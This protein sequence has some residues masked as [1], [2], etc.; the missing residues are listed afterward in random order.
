MNNERRL[1]EERG[2]LYPKAPFDFQKSLSFLCSFNAMKNEQSI[3]SGTMIKAFSVQGVPVVIELS[4]EGSVNC[5]IVSYVLYS[6]DELTESQ[7]QEV[8]DR[9]D[10]FLSLS[11]DL[12]AFYDIGSKDSYFEPVLRNCYGYHQV[13]FMTPFE[14]AC[15]AILVQRNPM[16]AACQLKRKLYEGY[17]RTLTVKGTEHF[18]FPEPADLLGASTEALVETFGSKRA[19]YLQAV[20]RA[21]AQTEAIF[22]KAG[23]YASVREWLLS[24]K[25]IGQWSVDFIL[26]R[27]LGRM[28]QI[29]WQE[30]AA[31]EAASAVYHQ[32]LSAK[33]VKEIA[34]HFGEYQGYCSI[35]FGLTILYRSEQVYLYNLST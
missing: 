19:E 13:K 14:N 6:D 2:F 27:G 34:D 9:I 31:I 29:P 22:M 12:T 30:K 26:I 7:A 20:A 18:T 24:I 11:D 33:Q 1:E 17:G 5:P 21:F 10:F 23:D 28:E 8:L 25:G 32:P 16:P 35:I 3:E 4:S 15:W